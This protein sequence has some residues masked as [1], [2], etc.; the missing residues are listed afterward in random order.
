MLFFI[1]NNNVTKIKY[2]FPVLIVFLILT[3]ENNGH[4]THPQTKSDDYRDPT[5]RGNLKEESYTQLI[6]MNSQESTSHDG[7]KKELQE[8]KAKLAELEKKIAILEG[9]I[10]EKYPNVKFLGVKERKRIIVSTNCLLTIAKY[11]LACVG[12]ADAVL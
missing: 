3:R 1:L 5:Y 8:T 12:A 7:T 9:R 11:L 10:P 2:I 4:K 6:K